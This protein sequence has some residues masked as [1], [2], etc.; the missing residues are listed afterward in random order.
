MLYVP[1]MYLWEYQE[2]KIWFVLHAGISADS[3]IGFWFE[4]RRAS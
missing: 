1:E 3:L 4:P 2:N